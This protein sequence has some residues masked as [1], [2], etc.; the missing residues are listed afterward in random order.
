MR[1]RT[2]NNIKQRS[3]KLILFVKTTY[4]LCKNEIEF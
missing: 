3:K 4:V 1:F 2:E